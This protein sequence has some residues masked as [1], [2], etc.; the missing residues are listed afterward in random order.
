MKNKTDAKFASQGQRQSSMSY[1]EGMVPHTVAYA[2]DVNYFGYLIDDDLYSVCKEVLNLLAEYG[3]APDANDFTQLVTTIKSK[4]AGSH[5]LTGLDYNSYTAAPTQ[6]GNSISFPAFSVNFCTKGYYG[7]KLSDFTKVSV[8]AQTIS[9]SSSDATGVWYIYVTNHG[10]ITKSQTAPTGDE[11]A[12]KCLLGSVYVINPS[13]FQ[14]NSWKFTPWLQVTCVETRES[15]TAETK[16]GYLSATSGAGLA[17]GPLDIK[18]EGINFDANVQKPNILHIDAIPTFTY[19]FLYKGYNPAASA[20]SS[21]DTTHIYNLTSASWESLNTATYG[22]K[23]MVMVPCI[24]PTG[25]TLMIPAM[26]TKTGTVYDSL[27][28]TPAEAASAVYGLKYVYNDHDGLEQTASRAIYLGFSLIVKVGATDLTNPENFAIAGMVPQALAGF[29]NAGGQT[30]GGAGAYIPMPEI[31][32][33]ASTAVTLVNNA[34]NVIIGNSTALTLTL[35][36]PVVGKVNQ[37]QVV[38]SPASGDVQPVFD[39]VAWWDDTP[40]FVDG[41]DYLVVIEYI[42]GR[43]KAGYIGG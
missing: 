6:N 7:D 19:K 25:Q 29:T 42:N 35:P 3:V 30:G 40:V 11:G 18:M 26:S 36:S 20:S 15:P 17:M 12:T 43:W 24:T 13:G 10:V 33:P 5:L 23:Y 22:D 39:T 34:S 32:H 4:M 14:A 9:A 31:Q 21:L 27:F 38:Y 2:E 28:D 16:G 1:V 41:K 8:D 37:L